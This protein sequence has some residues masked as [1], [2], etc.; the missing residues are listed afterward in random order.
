MRP[1]LSVAQEQV[2]AGTIGAFV[3]LAGDP[4]RYLLSNNHVL[5]D[6]DRAA[7]GSAVLSPGP[8]DG[9]DAGDRIGSLTRAVRLKPSAPN[10][11]DAALALLDDDVEIDPTY[12]VG[13]L[14]GTAEADEDPEVEKVGRTTGLTRGTVTAIE[15]DGVAVGFPGGTVVFDGQ[16]EV[17]GSHGAFSAGGDS[18]SLVYQP[19]GRRAVGLLFAG[20]ERGGPGG[21]GLTF[22]N[23]VDTVLAALGVTLLG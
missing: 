12:P 4:R 5:A 1:G 10:L 19:A 13:A 23:P 14:T 17:T 9:G 15:L 16:V 6:S 3:T 7:R 20:S 21:S 8:A 22:C 11:V 2:S 18:G